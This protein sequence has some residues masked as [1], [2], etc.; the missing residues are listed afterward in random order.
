M[1]NKVISNRNNCE[2]VN[3]THVSGYYL[4]NNYKEGITKINYGIGKM[5]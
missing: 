4:I 2:V 5:T 1:K 3:A